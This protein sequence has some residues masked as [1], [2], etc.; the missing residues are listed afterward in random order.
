MSDGIMFERAGANDW[1]LRCAYLEEVR[2][3]CRARFES[4]EVELQKWDISD[5]A[6]IPGGAGILKLRRWAYERG[7][8]FRTKVYRIASVED[9]EVFLADFM[10]VVLQHPGARILKP[11]LD[12]MAGL[13]RLTMSL[14]TGPKVVYLV[15]A[16]D[17]IRWEET[18]EYGHRSIA[19]QIPKAA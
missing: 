15:E 1:P 13:T 19:V 4:W 11:Q 2:E 8:R 9:F 10:K 17:R 12:P 5:G 14:G 6:T 3:A 16:D 18:D 7:P